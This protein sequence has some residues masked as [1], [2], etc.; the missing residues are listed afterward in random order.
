LNDIITVWHAHKYGLVWH[1]QTRDASGAI[2]W[3]RREILS[4]EPDFDSDALRM[5]QLHALA[6]ADMNG[7]GLMDIIAGKRWWAHG[8]TGD[9]E[10]DAPAQLY[11]FELIRDR[12]GARFAPHLIDSDC[13]AGTQIAV[14]DLRGSGLVDIVISNKKGVSLLLHNTNR[15]KKENLK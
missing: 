10:S 11:W 14:A 12:D 3:E 2:T 8:P 15:S 4:V 7:N 9:P 5:T 13:G 6:L 1:K